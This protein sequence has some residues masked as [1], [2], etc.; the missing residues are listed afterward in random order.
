MSTPEPEKINQAYEI[1]AEQLAGRTKQ[2]PAI[3]Q[4]GNY[5]I[6]GALKAEAEN[7][8]IHDTYEIGLLRAGAGIELSDQITDILRR[9]NFA[10][11]V[12][13]LSYAEDHE[14]AGIVRSP[15]ST[16]INEQVFIDGIIASGS[17]GSN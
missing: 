1:L 10:R 2:E 16:R 13:S 15:K 14:V 5:M 6:V 7:R 8:D 11:Y 12:F 3:I 4:L 17:S 9:R